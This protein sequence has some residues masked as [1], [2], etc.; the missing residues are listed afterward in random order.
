MKLFCNVCIIVFACTTLSVSCTKKEIITRTTT[1]TVL[2]R[3]I[4]TNFLMNAR[5]WIGFSYQSLGLIDSGAS[6]YVTTPEGIR[7]RGQ[8]Y[9]LGTRIQTKSEIGIYNK[10]LYFKWKGNG[11]GQ[12][13]AF[14]VQLKYDPFTNDGQVPIQGVDLATFSV[15]G[16]VP[17][18]TLIQNDTWYYTRV[19]PV[20]GTDNYQ[21]I[22][23]FGNYNH[24]GGNVIAMRT[25]PIY[26]KSGFLAVRMGDCY[27]GIAAFGVLGECRIASN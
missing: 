21:V 3:A 14:V 25:V 6:S 23:A 2:L 10:T 1:D 15:N 20:T 24:L 9:R 5:S 16:T 13:A 4:D 7:F 22:T 19:Q 27:A 18:S 8:G 17:G 26:T 12:F 11:G